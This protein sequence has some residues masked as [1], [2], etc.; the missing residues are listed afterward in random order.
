[1][2]PQNGVSTKNVSSPD[3]FQT[4]R[5]PVS[6]DRSETLVSN[7]LGNQNNYCHTELGKHNI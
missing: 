5:V 3:L 2:V 4:F 1:M 7:E 6:L